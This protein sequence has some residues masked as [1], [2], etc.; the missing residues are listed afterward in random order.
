MNKSELELRTLIDLSFI[1]QDFETVVQ[2]AEYPIADF[3]KI[4][5]F[6]NATHC[7]EILLF[8]KMIHDK[9]LLTANFK[10]FV[11]V[12]DR[13]FDTYHKRALSPSVVITKFAIYLSEIYQELGR[14]KE[15][16][17]I[18]IKLAT[19]L[20]DKHPSKPLFFE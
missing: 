17:D 14:N 6:K 10:E 18:F 4:Q 9:N 11:N 2:N 15:A 8:S 7:E 20:N 16:S 12:A 5:A 1:V 3:K 13:I 19:V